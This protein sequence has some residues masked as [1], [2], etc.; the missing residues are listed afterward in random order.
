MSGLERRLAAGELVV[1]GEMPV[2]NSGGLDIVRE[3]LAPMA[4]YL[5]AIN[6]T[7]NPS[8][9]ASSAATTSSPRC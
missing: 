4:P 2:I 7:D 5:D 9:R 8:A 1:T 3:Q 6:A